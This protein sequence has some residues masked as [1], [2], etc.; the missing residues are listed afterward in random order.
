MNGPQKVRYPQDYIASGEGSQT[1][2]AGCVVP[3]R[4]GRLPVGTSETP[5]DDEP[6]L[7]QHTPLLHFV[8]RIYW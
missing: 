7:P 2:S 6:R 5:A 8:V 1:A 4:R 3:A